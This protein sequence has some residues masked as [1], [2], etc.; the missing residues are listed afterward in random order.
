MNTKIIM[1]N[2]VC[3]T[4]M[5]FVNLNFIVSMYIWFERSFVLDI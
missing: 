5:K 4:M 3:F 1:E 2:K